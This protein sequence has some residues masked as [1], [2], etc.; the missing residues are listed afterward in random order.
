[1]PEVKRF[2]EFKNATGESADLYIYGDIVS[3]KWFENDVTANEFRKELNAIGDVKT[4]NIY[5]NSYGGDVFQGQAIYSMLKRHKASKTVYIDGIAASA[6]SFIA[7]SGDKIIMPSNAMMM[8]HR[9]WTIGFGNANDFLKLAADM[10]KIDESIMST[11]QDKTGMELEKIK[12][13]MDDETWM[14]ADDAV[15]MGFADEI[16]AEKKVAAS[17]SNTILIINGIQTDMSR[18][19]HTDTLIKK[20]SAY[21]QP[22]EE[23]KNEPVKEPK[24]EPRSAPVDLYSIITKNHER[25]SRV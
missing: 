8:I 10:D 18:F 15:E 25:R 5:I 9:A 1:M 12:Q 17:I 21:E 16:E 7:M 2:F 3:Y 11:Y 6:A 22:K 4:L 13:L 23:P 19:K 24:E 20:F 14:N